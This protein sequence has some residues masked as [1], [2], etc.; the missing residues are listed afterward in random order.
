[1]TTR[2]LIHDICDTFCDFLI[3]Y[4]SLIAQ[5]VDVDCLLIW[6][7]MAG[8]GG[9]LISPAHFK[10]FLTPNYKKMV[11]FA[12]DAGI[13]IVIT[14]S[15][16]YVED[17]IPLIVETGV[18]GMYP[19]ERAAGNDLM[20]IRKNFPEFRIIGGIDKRVLF[21]DSGTSRIDTELQI[22]TRNALSRKIYTPYRS[23]CLPG[24]HLEKFY[25]LPK[26]VK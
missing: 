7:D 23:F 9:S 8:R 6:E 19:F 18:T 17:I 22:V 4:Y 1:M 3:E 24:L 13:D 20:R 15:D 21:E 16:G 14:D 11:R 10:E 26:Q 12:K 5:D 2:S 25:L